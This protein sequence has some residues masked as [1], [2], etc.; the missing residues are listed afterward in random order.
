MAY[1]HKLN[2]PA[3]FLERHHAGRPQEPESPSHTRD[4]NFPALQLSGLDAFSRLSWAIKIN[5]FRELEI[6]ADSPAKIFRSSGTSAQGRSRSAFSEDGLAAYRKSITAGFFTALNDFCPGRDSRQMNGISLVPPPEEWPESS[7]AAM[8]GWIARESRVIHAGAEN[9]GDAVDQSGLQPIWVFGTAFHFVPLLEAGTLPR[10]PRGSVVIYTGGTKGKTRDITES[11]LIQSLALGFGVPESNVITEYGMSELASAAYTVKGGSCLDPGERRLRFQS[12]AVPFVVT[13]CTDDMPGLRYFGASHGTGLLG[14]IDLNRVDLPAPVIT[15]DVVRLSPDGDF[16]LLGRAKLAPLKGCSLL[17]PDEPADVLPGSYATPA[18]TSGQ[19]FSF[20]TG[21][22][23]R[24]N[25]LEAVIQ[26]LESEAASSALARDLASKTAARFALQDA[27]HAAKQSRGDALF[28]AIKNSEAGRWLESA[29]AGPAQMLMIP[30]NTHPVAL[31]HPLTLALCAGLQPV[32]RL[33]RS[34][35]SAQSFTG[36]LLHHLRRAGIVVPVVGSQFRFGSAM[37][38]TTSAQQGTEGFVAAMVFG[39]DETIRHIRGATSIP[40]IGH[41]G[42]LTA[43]LARLEDIPAQM[44]AIVLDTFALMQEGCMASRLLGLVVPATCDQVAAKEA[45]SSAFKDAWWK[46]WGEA[47]SPLHTAGL[48]THGLPASGPGLPAVNFCHEAQPALHGPTLQVALIAES[49]LETII[50][51]WLQ[52]WPQLKMLTASPGLYGLIEKSANR[53]DGANRMV[54][55]HLG[56]ANR[57]QWDGLHFGTPV[58][59]RP[60]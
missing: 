41:G 1:V 21:L 51:A 53:H 20:A 38:G 57:P 4:W 8:I 16:Q 23:P 26:F 60:C 25:I 2:L 58:F 15:E 50:P 55:R 36:E 35:E 37:E 46:V 24:Q 7:L 56:S 48:L 29:K 47:L 45:I 5:A 18:R 32:V 6:G 42:A 12:G 39:D 3:G 30:P 33:P 49:S 28:E 19:T 17:A 14:V 31:L 11:A 22:R 27:A 10:L 44:P 59:G 52:K 40:V 9:L 54:V 13:A 34:Q 43:S